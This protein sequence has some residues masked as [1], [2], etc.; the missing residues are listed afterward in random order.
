MENKKVWF[1][2]GASKGF[3]LSLT[4]QLLKAGHQVAATSR[5]TDELIK[6]L[7]FTGD[8]FLPLQVDLADEASVC[9][10]ID[11][12]IHVFN[13]IDVVANNAGYGIGGSIEELTAK[14]TRDSFDINVF[15]TIK[16]YT[17]R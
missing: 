17:Q 2:T 8:A 7:N 4:K 15:G 10:A 13:R 14:E 6:A 3:G 5:D 16:R 1:I 9:D 12:T 11:K